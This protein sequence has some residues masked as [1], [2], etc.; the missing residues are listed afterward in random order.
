MDRAV[1]AISK[2][3]FE[4]DKWQPI[5]NILLFTLPKFRVPKYL[6]S[7]QQVLGLFDFRQ[8]TRLVLRCFYRKYSGYTI[9]LTDNM[10]L[11]CALLILIPVLELLACTIRLLPI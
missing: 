6:R 5:L 2:K 11:Y 9:R 7:I 1:F 3:P 10:V 4:D 8:S